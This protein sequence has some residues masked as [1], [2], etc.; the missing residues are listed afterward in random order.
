M[1]KLARKLLLALLL[2]GAAGWL[3]L[4]FFDANQLKKPVLGWLNEHTELDIAIG[5][6][7]FNPLHPY[8]LL[9]EDVRLGDWFQAKQ[10]YLE[11]ARL[12]PLAGHTRIA[13]LDVIDGQVRLDRATDLTLPD[14]LANITVD[15]LNTKNLI[16]AWDGWEA[17]GANLKLNGW[18]PRR[19]GDWRWWSDMTL[20]GQVRQLSHP[21]LEMSRISLEG[22]IH[23]RQLQIDNVRSRLFDGLFEASLSLDPTSRELTLNG[24]RFS[25]NKLQFS[26]APALPEGWTLLLNRASLQDLSITSPWLTANG[27]DG[28][29]RY[30]EWQPGALPEARGDWQADEAVLDWLRLDAHQGQLL[31]NRERLGL[32]LRGKAYQGNLEAELGWF[33]QQ[34]RLDIDNLQLLDSKL[35]WLPDLH[36]PVP[37][38]RIHKL[39]LSQTELL[40]ADPALPLS[41]HGGQLFIT[42]LAWSTEQW[43]PLS[44]Q[45]RLEGGWNELAYD[46]LISRRGSFSAR[47]DDTRLLLDELRGEFLEGTVRLSGNLGLYPPHRARLQL[48]AERLALR[49]LSSW[50]RGERGFSGTLSMSAT[51]AGEPKLPQSWEGNLALEGSDVFIERLGLDNW[52]K[53]RLGEDYTRPRQVD[54]LLAALDLE[55]SDAFIYKTELKGPVAQG[56][57]QLDGSAV[58]SV[59]H[60][61]AIRGKL[62]FAGGW[63]LDLGAINDQ[64]CRELA[65]RLEESWAAPRLRL[66]Q[67]ALDDPCSP[68][69]RGPVPYPAAG[70]PGRL[71]EAVRNLPQEP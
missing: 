58:Q 60:L 65:I 16:L 41:L 52:L 15:E 17:Q 56:Q 47:L 32:S 42:D 9:A 30:L 25:H 35:E 54:P 70:L 23:R 22:R 57:W 38:V 59:R 7:E 61:L 66:H 2:L 69:Y 29:L 24:P 6:L 4:S 71:T 34:G 10:L 31:S 11:L 18:Q 21:W 3:L 64:G 44:D 51:L 46:S 26:Q 45:A 63:Q 19:N 53:A 55:S 50:L 13:V 36:W 39:N 12:S 49:R 1:R 33:P 40:S 27:I 62:D 43:R 28:S 37:D 5:R 68:W 48:E 20:S 8:K 14:N 67:P